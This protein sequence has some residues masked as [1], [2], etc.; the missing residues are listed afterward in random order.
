MLGETYCPIINNIKKVIMK[1]KF[2]VFAFVAINTFITVPSI[3]Q[4]T[5]KNSGTRISSSNNDDSQINMTEDGHS[6]KIRLNGTRVLEMEVDGKK[7]AESDFNKYD[8]LI[9]KILKQMEEDRKQAE[10]DRKQAEKDREQ[11]DK[12]RAQAEL[13]RKQAEKDRMQADEDRKQAVRDRAQADKDRISAE[14]DRKQ[15]EKDRA[16]AEL[17]RKQA[18]KDRAQAEIDR[19]QAEE[20]RKIFEQMVTELISEK[21]VESR[22]ALTSLTLDNK[23]L[24]INGVKQSDAMQQK[25]AAKYLKDKNSRMQ[26]N[27]HN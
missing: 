17:D 6:Y 9:K 12:D 19:K 2:F 3:A 8:A 25:F 24:T 21:L 4:K 20:D 10:L 7:I 13:D 5:E 14:G 27:M 11:A 18:E 1:N 26:F 23:E 15:A 22:N 16:Q